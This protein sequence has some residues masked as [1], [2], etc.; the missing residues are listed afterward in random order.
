MD[1]IAT[2]P[3]AR[4]VRQA[5]GQRTERRRTARSVS[6]VSFVVAASVLLG[7]GCAT[8]T[9]V[10]YD[11]LEAAIQAGEDVD[12]RALRAAFVATPDFAERMENISDL[13]TQ[14]IQLIEEEPLRLGPL[15]SAIIDQ[16]PGSLA[17]HHA[18]ATFYSY[19]EREDIAAEHRKWVSRIRASVE[20]A[21]EGT[22]ESPLS[23]ISQAE[24]NAYL[25]ATGRTPVG[26]MYVPTDETPFLLSIA[27]KPRQGRIEI[28][29]F[30]LDPVYARMRLRDAQQEEA[31][32]HPMRVL[33]FLANE[34]DSAAG[35]FFGSL[36]LGQRRLDD[37][38]TLLARASSNGNLIAHLLLARAYS[39]RAMEATPG[40][41]RDAARLQV[42]ANYEHGID[43]GS[44]EA[45]YELGRL[46]TLGHY[47]EELRAEGLELLTRAAD[48]DNPSA[49]LLLARWFE[50]A[51]PPDRPDYE[52]SAEYYVRAASLDNAAAKLDYARF[53]MREEVNRDFTDQAYRWLTGL[54]SDGRP[55]EATP[56][57]C[58]QARVQLGNLFAKG[59]H[60]RRNYRKARSW[61]RSAVAA[62]PERAEVV[63]DVAWTLTVS[64]L[65][66]LRDERYAL[67][68]MDRVMTRDERARGVPAYIDTWAAAYAAN[69]DFDRAI[70]LQRE[71]LEEALNEDNA[72]QIDDATIEILREHLQAFEAGRTITDAIP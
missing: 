18:L 28:V 44:D 9:L 63:N 50:I 40:P 2:T 37:A 69:G 72:Q 29:Y 4:R 43:V 46:Y 20:A 35:T 54:A 45:M 11:Q 38:T 49:C 67:K 23:V 7:A 47:G 60:V 53:L 22:F 1:Q 15:G 27:A 57:L 10:E 36:R 33:S 66:R 3:P 26:A 30:D 13:E 6:A 70:E 48:L 14:A 25:I 31:D 59:I 5:V 58:A 65:E 42:V 17:G 64:N 32:L 55:C 56:G 24:P 8:T 34:N 71:A 61:L 62:S 16:Y 21:A 68:I 12:V 39:Y 41:E 19:L 51:S 52:R